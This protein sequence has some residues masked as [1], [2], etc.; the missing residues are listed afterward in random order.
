MPA[1]TTASP[2]FGQFFHRTTTPIGHSTADF[3]AITVPV[4]VVTG[5][6]DMFCSVESACAADRAL[7]SGELCVVPGAG[8]EVTQAVIEAIIDFLL[9]NAT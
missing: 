4:L 5:D 8:H 9:R 7:T 3:A 1:S 2:A 6:R